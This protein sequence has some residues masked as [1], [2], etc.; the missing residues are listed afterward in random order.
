[1]RVVSVAKYIE[2]P[3]S[4]GIVNLVLNW[5]RAASEAGVDMKVV[6][7]GSG[8]SGLRSHLGVEIEYVATTK[9]RFPPDAASL[10]RFQAGI[11]RRADSELVHFAENADGFSF[12]P[13]LSVL[14][15]AQKKVLNTYPDSWIGPL[16]P[17]RPIVFDLTTVTSERMLNVLRSRR[18]FP[19]RIRVIPPCVD[20]ERFQ[21]RDRAQ[22]RDQLGLPP[23]AFIVFAVG[24]VKRS[25]RLLEL[26]TLMRELAKDVGGARLVLATTGLGDE[27]VAT[28]LQSLVGQGELL[29]VVSP[30][31]KIHLYYNAADLYVLTAASEGVIETPLSLVEAM[32]SGTPALAFD[33]KACSEMVTSGEEGFIVPD[34]DFAGLGRAILRFARDES[35]R[36][37]CSGRA[38]DRALRDFSYKSVGLRLLS[39]YK[40]LG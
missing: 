11:V 35:L 40:E 39:T 37:Y 21:P 14:R 10:L 23:D 9:K 28:Q 38:R 3:F 34:G 27:G 25:R 17:I 29:R 15:L 26:V 32:A 20:T 1:M 36:E 16:G 24:H 31:D 6:S 33:V 8:P 5:A 13:S 12:L 19:P 2:P 22:V 4:E 7:L 18:F 30:T